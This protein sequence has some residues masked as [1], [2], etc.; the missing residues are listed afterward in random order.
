MTSNAF[1]SM[2]VD[3]LDARDSRLSNYPRRWNG[4][5]SQEFLVIR[6]NHKTGEIYAFEE[7]WKRI[8]ALIT[9]ADSARSIS[10]SKPRAFSA[11]SSRFA[12]V[13]SLRE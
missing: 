1:L 2:R 6:H 4:A 7:W 9:R 11:A 3:G 10:G 13:M 12:S 5:P 8:E